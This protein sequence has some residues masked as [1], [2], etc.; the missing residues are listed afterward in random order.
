MSTTG[1]QP[2]AEVP[3][4][5]FRVHTAKSQTIYFHDQRIYKRLKT[6]SFEVFPHLPR[7]KEEQE[8]TKKTPC[9]S[10]LPV[11]DA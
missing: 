3:S 6:T 11:L 4:N 1:K 7:I 9:T 2:E 8:N 10:A 5:F